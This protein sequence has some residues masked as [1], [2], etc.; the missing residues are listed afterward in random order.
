MCFPN[1]L[2]AASAPIFGGIA[3]TGL[4]L[5][6]LTSVYGTR[7]VMKLH[8]YFDIKEYQHKNT[9]K[10]TA[11][12]VLKW[13]AIAGAT[14]VGAVGVLLATASSFLMTSA[15]VVTIP[16]VLFITATMTGVFLTTA[17]LAVREIIAPP[18]PWER[19]TTPD[20]SVAYR[21]KP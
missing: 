11:F 17:Y 5:G 10:E 8:S 16:A 9:W 12:K 2:D 19:I 14:I 6:G 15:L 21:Y 1:G 4:I 3:T 13:A 7:T 18:D 20:G